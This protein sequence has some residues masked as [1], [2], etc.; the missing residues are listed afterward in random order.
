M[1]QNPKTLHLLSEMAQ[2]QP[3]KKPTNGIF[4][5]NKTETISRL[6]KLLLINLIQLIYIK[7]NID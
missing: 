2:K 4:A 5:H 1:F 7:K 6:S 3:T